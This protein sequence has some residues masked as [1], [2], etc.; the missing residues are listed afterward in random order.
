MKEKY[1]LLAKVLQKLQNEEVLDNF[2]LTGSWCNYYYHILFKKAPEVPLI[3]TTDIDFLIPN[4]LKATKDVNVASILNE[5]GF[6]NDFD[7]GSGLVKYVHPDLE[8]Q[9]LTPMLGRG[10]V[11][12]YEI[13]KLNINAEGLRYL[14]PLQDFKFKMKHDG[15]TIWLPEPEVFVL[16]KILISQKRKDTAKSEK[17]LLTAKNI[18]ELCLRDSKRRRRLKEIY[19]IFPVKWQKTILNISEGISTELFNYLSI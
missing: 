3:R 6:D 18:G 17:D 19:Q 2:I 1:N 15:I 14:K 13:K 16:Q 5:I 11:T 8:I 7:Y 9:F 12:P 10:K 4:P